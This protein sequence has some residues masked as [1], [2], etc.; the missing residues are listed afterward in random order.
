MAVQDLSV[1]GQ[2][3]FF[4]RS[5]WGGILYMVEKEPE[6]G[7]QEEGVFLMDRQTR[8]KTIPSVQFTSVP[9]P[10]YNNIQ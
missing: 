1:E 9:Q 2:P 4:N 3:P 8:L 6:P 5:G 7:I 10:F